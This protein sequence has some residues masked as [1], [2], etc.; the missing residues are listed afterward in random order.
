MVMT[1][2]FAGMQFLPISLRTYE[3]VLK[4]LFAGEILDLNLAAFQAGVKA[5]S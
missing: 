5:V 4:G 2:A 3:T 1:G